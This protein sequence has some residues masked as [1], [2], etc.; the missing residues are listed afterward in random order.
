[1][2]MRGP[3]I[4]IEITW[5]AGACE[6]SRKGDVLLLLGQQLRLLFV[7]LNLMAV[8][9]TY[10]NT[11][12]LRVPRNMCKTK[13]FELISLSKIRPKK[14]IP[15]IRKNERVCLKYARIMFLIEIE[16][17]AKKKDC[18]NVLEREVLNEKNMFS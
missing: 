17:L 3:D 9:G 13:G 2:S 16:Y 12:Q 10:L 14:H 11:G 15:L 1:M 6:R 18:Q 7:V 8:E 4:G 5:A